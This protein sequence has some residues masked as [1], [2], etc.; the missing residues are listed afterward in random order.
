MNDQPSEALEGRREIQQRLYSRIGAERPQ[1]VAHTS[2]FAKGLRHYR[3][4]MMKYL[5]DVNSPNAS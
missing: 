1:S 4:W 2:Y 5:V 3:K